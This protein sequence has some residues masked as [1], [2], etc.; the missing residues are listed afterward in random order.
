MGWNGLDSRLSLSSD[1]ESVSDLDLAREY[2]KSWTCSIAADQNAQTRYRNWRK[3]QQEHAIAS[4][5]VKLGYTKSTYA[6]II[7]KHTDIRHTLRDDR[8]PPGVVHCQYNICV[9]YREKPSPT[10][11][12][13]N[14]GY[15]PC[16]I[17]CKQLEQSESL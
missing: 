15:Y 13:Q 16:S 1:V 5:L 17:N 10:A 11:D 4:A 8:N 14:H 6:G 12:S 9:F 2:A 7:S 3:D